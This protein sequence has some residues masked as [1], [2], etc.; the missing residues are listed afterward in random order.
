MDLCDKYLFDFI[1]IYPPMN[2]YLL[3]SKFTK[4]QGIL[5]NHLSKSFVKKE[6]KL[7]T[8]FIKLLQKKKEKSSCEEIL[9]YDLKFHRRLSS[10]DSGD[11]LLDINDNILFMYYEICMN[12]LTPLKNKSDY[13][14]VM[15][16]LKSLTSITNDIINI[17]EKGLKNKIMLNKLIIDYFIKKCQTILSN[18]IS[19]KNV[20][21]DIRKK[22]IKYIDNFII[23]NIN[24]LY[25]FIIEKYYKNCIE[26][27]GL[28][29]Y[30]KGK[31][32]YDKLCKYNS[33]SSLTPQN[34]HEFGLNFLKQDL[35]LKKELAKKLKVD[36]IDDYIS[37]NNKFY[38]S[39]SEILS[40]LNKQKDMMYKKLSK[41]FYDDIDKLYKIKPISAHNDN[42]TAYYYGPDNYNKGVGEFYMNISNPSNISKYELLILSIH[43]G[44]PGHHYEGYLL[45]KSDK[46]DY[47]KTNLYSGYSEGWALYCESLYEYDNDFEYYY[48]LQYK[49]ERSLR[50]IIDTGIHYLN[51]D[52]NKCFQFMKKYLN[53]SD[54]YIKNQIFRYSSNPGQA[55]SY[56]IGEQVILHLKKDFMKK[57]SDIKAF[58]KIILD[59]G[60]CPLDILVK[61]YYELIL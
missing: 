59:I 20:P 25:L 42:M 28:C 40:D 29:S 15:N 43:E 5:P 12:K 19:P 53:Y 14:D 54:E 39:S 44:I 48:S 6:T 23:K 1:N 45:Y 22:F 27:L 49:I 2:D 57:N 52:Y 34:I 26:K 21:S 18:K 30:I 8:E 33:L 60:S 38:S 58:H 32:Y 56:K 13:E 51:W 46:S 11:F 9:E 4:K 41:Y 24:K 37:K 35:K 31:S 47:V 10:F 16:R 36:D 55:V 3:Y 17:L 7:N 61:R 50:L